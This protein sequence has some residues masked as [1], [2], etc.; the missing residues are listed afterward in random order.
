MPL[1]RRFR[2]GSRRLSLAVTLLAA[3]L[4]PVAGGWGADAPAAVHSSLWPQT[5]WPFARDAK[6][7]ARVQA[8]LHKMTLEQKVGQIIQADIGSVT[9]DE[10][11]KYRLG[12][13]VAGGNSKL[14]GRRTAD[15]AQWQATADAFYRAS[16]DPRGGVP[17]PV[18]FGIDAVHGDNA[19][20]GAKLFPPKSALGATP[21]PALV[22]A[23]G[24]APAEEV[25]A[26]G[27]DWAFAPTLAVPQDDRWGRTYEGYSEN[28]A[29]VAQYATAA[30]EG[31]QWRAARRPFSTVRT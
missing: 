26:T 16:M 5:H 22:R 29:L 8:L 31:L 2:A 20:L 19:T 9:P 11:R 24:A 1:S 15:A 6:L 12:S 25:R 10:V 28:P 4:T 13:G 14:G 23:I 3:L 17:I 27:L 7:E 21:A 18:L 30:V